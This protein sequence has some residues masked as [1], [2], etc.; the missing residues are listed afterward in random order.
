M[1]AIAEQV[2]AGLILI[3]AHILDHFIQTAIHIMQDTNSNLIKKSDDVKLT[4]MDTTLITQDC[5][6]RS[7][8]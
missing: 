2:A 4:G 8:I 1:S 3:K 7:V 5:Q 6:S